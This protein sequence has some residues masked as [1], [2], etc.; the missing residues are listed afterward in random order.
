[1]EKMKLH[2]VL[3]IEDDATIVE[4]I[5][6]QFSEDK[7]DRGYNIMPSH[8]LSLADLEKDPDLEMSSISMGLICV[9]YNLPGGFNGNDVIKKIRSYEANK[10]VI[11]IFYSFAKNEIELKAILEDSIEDTSNI[12]YVHQNDLEDRIILILEE[13]G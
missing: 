8:F 13:I 4:G 12:Y 1:M 6:K 5:V 3:W 7:D 10:N 9:D 2:N 11:I